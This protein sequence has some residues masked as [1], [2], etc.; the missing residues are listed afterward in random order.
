MLLEHGFYQTTLTNFERQE[1][2][3]HDGRLFT[4]S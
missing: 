4:R 1:L 2:R 3:G